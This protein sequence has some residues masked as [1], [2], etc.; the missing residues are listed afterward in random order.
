MKIEDLVQAETEDD[1]KNIKTW[2]FNEYMKVSNE[3]T[4]L[5]E[6]KKAFIRDRAKFQDERNFFNRKII[7]EKQRL[8]DESVFFDKKMQIL[9]EGFRQLEM[10]RKQFEREKSSFRSE[11]SRSDL[12]FSN[13]GQLLFA[14]VDSSLGL[15]KRYRDL[16]KIFHPDNLC[17]DERVVQVINQEYERKLL[18]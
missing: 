15:K 7:F 17:G 11:N 13:F 14:G 5:E 9:Q 12:Q 3:K 18:E 8:K 16:I 10:D 6:S 1:F 2:L 4:K